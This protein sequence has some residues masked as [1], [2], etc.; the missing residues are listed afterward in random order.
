M[1]IYLQNWLTIE[2]M[3]PFGV[4]FYFVFLRHMKEPLEALDHMP[5][6]MFHISK[7]L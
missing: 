6:E 7:M 4:L 1:I 5:K 2:M 3:V